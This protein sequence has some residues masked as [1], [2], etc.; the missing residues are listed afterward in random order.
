MAP[1]ANPKA[2]GELAAKPVPVARAPDPTTP[3][4]GTRDKLEF[5]VKAVVAFVT[6]SEATTTCA[7]LGVAGIVNAQAVPVLPGKL[8]F[9]SEEQVQFTARLANETVI[10]AFAAN[11][12][13]VALTRSPTVP[14]VAESENVAMSGREA[15][16]AERTPSPTDPVAAPMV[17]ASVDRMRIAISIKSENREAGRGKRLPGVRSGSTGIFVA[18]GLVR[19]WEVPNRGD[20]PVIRAVTV[21]YPRPS[22]EVPRCM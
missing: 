1:P 6:P 3:L 17:D 14:D 18:R 12:L 20:Q 22:V 8:P 5:T 10:E 7:P 16:T 21:P 2:M 19:R 9:E 15:S 13:P 4:M 11:P